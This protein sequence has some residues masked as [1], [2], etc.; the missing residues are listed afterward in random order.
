MHEALFRKDVRSKAAYRSYNSDG[1]PLPV[2]HSQIVAF[3][4]EITELLRILVKP[5]LTLLALA[6]IAGEPGPVW[7]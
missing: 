2:G 4:D 6:Q 1:P 3:T 5:I 7:F